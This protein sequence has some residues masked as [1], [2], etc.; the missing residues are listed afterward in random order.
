MANSLGNVIVH[1]TCYTVCS[2]MCPISII[3][4]NVA[5]YPVGLLYMLYAYYTYILLVSCYII[6][7]TYMYLLYTPVLLL[8]TW[9]V[10]RVVNTE[11]PN[12]SQVTPADRLQRELLHATAPYHVPSSAL[13]DKGAS[14]E[15]RLQNVECA[16]ATRGKLYS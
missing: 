2:R 8:R 13:C 14:Y 15:Q 3:I 10:E 9:A 5:M 11:G 7:H 4:I 16:L 6:S 1:T 12:P